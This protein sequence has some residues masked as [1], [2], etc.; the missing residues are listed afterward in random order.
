MTAITG[1]LRSLAVAFPSVLRTNAHWH[2]HHP[3]MVAQAERH[4][5]AK[6]WG[7]QADATTRTSA[8]DRAMAPYLDDPFRGTVE[9][10]LR[11]T[12]ETALSMELR[13]ARAAL[14]AAG[15][16][17]RDIDL[18]LS[19]SFPGDRF[20]VGNAAYLAAELG[21]DSPAWNFESAC[22]GSVVGLHMASSLVR[23]GD[24]RRVLVVAST[25]NSALCVD[26]EGLS[27]L[28]G[29]GAGAFV[30][31]PARAGFGV[32]GSATVNTVEMNDMFVI[33]S[34]ALR[35][36]TTRLIGRASPDAGKI[37]R[38]TAEPLLRRCVDSALAKAHASVRDIDFWVFNTPN[39]WYADF[40]AAVLGVAEGR[41]HS[42]YPQH[43]NMGAALMPATLYE[44][45]HRGLVRAGQVVGLYSIG[46]TS[47]ASAV[48]LRLDDLALGPPPDAPA[49]IDGPSM[50]SIG[51]G[52]RP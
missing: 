41:Y 16:T 51:T 5:L 24:Y 52:P 7:R 29:D 43:A 26:D 11:A 12:G 18:T 44:A 20:G 6:L 8:F 21:L 10:R 33:H 34:V 14:S 13:A 2:R 42:I 19:T 9:R 17:T 36:G 31:E 48:V 40:C 37:G 28:T 45:W 47:T 15:L 38:E 39:A 4:A 25:S 23:S 35:D 1:G 3:E 46:S 49:T 27:W 22:S 30:V 50:A 32:L